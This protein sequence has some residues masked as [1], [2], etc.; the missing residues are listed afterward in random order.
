MLLRHNGIGAGWIHDSKLES[1]DFPLVKFGQPGKQL[2]AFRQKVNSY[3]PVVTCA[4]IFANQSTALGAL[5]ESYNGVV[6]L[7]QKFG[8]FGDR[9]PASAGKPGNTEKQLVLL[10]GKAV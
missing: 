3:D 9:S 10:R 4:M 5:D 2:F 1:P 6:A 7:L 8:Q